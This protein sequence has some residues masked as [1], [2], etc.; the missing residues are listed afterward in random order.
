[1]QFH[2]VSRPADLAVHRQSSS[3][4]GRPCAREPRKRSS[5]HLCPAPRQCADPSLCRGL[6]ST[7]SSQ[8][9]LL[10]LHVDDRG[11]PP[12]AIVTLLSL[13]ITSCAH[14]SLS[15]QFQATVQPSGQSSTARRCTIE[16]ARS[17]T[18]VPFPLALART[19]ARFKFQKF[20]HATELFLKKGRCEKSAGR[21][22]GRTPGVI[23]EEH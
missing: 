20:D 13:A 16:L 18:R 11:G 4:S 5:Q 15:S 23:K 21:D 6:A 19:K 1:M 17:P 10:R 7:R 9:A 8:L 22:Q 3:K 14:P 12:S 2:A